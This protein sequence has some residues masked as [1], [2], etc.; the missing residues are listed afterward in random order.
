MPHEGAPQMSDVFQS[1]IK[2]IFD[3]CDVEHTGH[4]RIARFIEV[5]KSYINNEEEIERIVNTLDPDD[6]GNINLEAF[7]MGISQLVQQHGVS[8]SNVVGDMSFSRRSSTITDDEQCKISLGDNSSATFNEYD[9]SPRND[10]DEHIVDMPHNKFMWAMNGVRGNYVEQISEDSTVVHLKDRFENIHNEIYN[11]TEDR[12]CQSERVARLQTESTDLRDRLVLIEERLQDMESG[13][14]SDSVSSKN[15]NIDKMLVKYQT[16]FDC[17]WRDLLN[18]VLEVEHELKRTKD[19]NQKIHK[20]M[21]MLRKRFDVLD[22][23]LRE[24][25]RLTECLKQSNEELVMKLEQRELH[26]KNNQEVM[27]RLVQQISNRDS[28]GI[29]VKGTQLHTPELIN[30]L[31]T[32]IGV[33]KG[34]NVRLKEHNEQLQQQ[35]LALQVQEG[36]SLMNAEDSWASELDMMSKEDLLARVH[37]L[38]A[39]NSRYT[40][41]IERMLVMIMKR[42]PNLLENLQT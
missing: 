13:I 36:Y 30:Q 20:A 3:F 34:E 22:E 27:E 8:M 4:I 14:F 39:S 37:E 38:Q 7:S 32:E 15:T 12:K 23:Q 9:L 31:R 21:G 17:E 1:Q 33:L 29:S 25:E 41:Y 42:D 10:E 28:A 24:N 5:A 26:D 18:R 19:E 16:T 40:S 11:I 2:E 35:V 6:V